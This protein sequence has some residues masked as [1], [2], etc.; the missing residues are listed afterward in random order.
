MSNAIAVVAG[1]GDFA[2]GIVS[3]IDQITGRGELLLPMSNRGLGAADIEAMLRDALAAAPVRVIFTDLPAGS[4]TIAARRVLR[5]RPDLRLVMGA[6]LP[7]VIDF[8]LAGEAAGD[9]AQ[10][11]AHAVERGRLALQEVGGAR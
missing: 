11:V 2:A 5:E 3:A 10:A 8:V 7:A 6:N 1:H 4:C 9:D